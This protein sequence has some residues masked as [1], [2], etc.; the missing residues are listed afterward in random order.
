MDNAQH[1]YD[2][3]ANEYDLFVNWP[4]RLAVELPFLVQVLQNIQ[5]KRVLDVA[6]GTG[7]HAMALV[8]A[9]YRVSL[10]DI[11]PAML[12]QAQRTAEDRHLEL[13]VELAGFGDLRRH[14]SEPFDVLLCL[15]NSIPHV[16]DTSSLQ[17]TVAD[18]ASVIRPGGVL[19]WQLRNFAHVLAVQERFMAPQG[20]GTL[21]D[22]WLFVRFYDF[23]P[24]RILFNMLKLRKEAGGKWRQQ[25]EQTLLYPWVREEIEP[26]LLAGGWQP[27]S[28]Y[29]NLKGEPFDKETSRDLVLVSRRAEN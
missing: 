6:G 5:A 29:G 7:Q 2:S 14:F 17:R 18:M 13:P 9:G 4:E 19:L 24:P 1:F 16:L 8:K 12:Q 25:L 26:V 21:Q 11:S 3:F 23:I 10:A 28:I 15:G 22:E 20:G 27:P